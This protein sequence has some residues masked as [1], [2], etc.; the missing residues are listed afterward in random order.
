M[1]EEFLYDMTNLEGTLNS[2]K[3]L[4]NVKHYMDIVRYVSDNKEE[5]SCKQFCEYF[6]IDFNQLNIENIY[7]KIMHVTTNDNC[8]KD[9][10]KYGLMP[11]S[12]VINKNTSLKKYLNKKNIN[13]D[14][15]NKLIKRDDRIIDLNN[16]KSN[17]IKHLYYKLY[18][19]GGID[20]FVSSSNPLDYAG[21]IKLRPEILS[22]I[23]QVFSDY[24][25][26]NDWRYNKNKDTYIINFKT[27]VHN[28]LSFENWD[29]EYCDAIEDF[30][31]DKECYIKK[32]LIEESLR[33]INNELFYNN[34][35]ENI[36]TL[37]YGVSIPKEDILEIVKINKQ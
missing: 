34:I 33:R 22:N 3:E 17:A 11:L 19:D 32:F 8:C 4:V 18:K 26:D 29:K 1:K 30:C 2:L 14:L 27:S 31:N 28:V 35:V 13:I 24:S 12:E 21:E 36:V 16:S 10:E 25:I 37:N 23:S 15:E 7:L 6:N 9:I 5:F 20:G